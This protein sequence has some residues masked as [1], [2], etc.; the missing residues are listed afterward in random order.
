MTNESAKP[1]RLSRNLISEAG[2]GIFVVALANLGFLIYLDATRENSNPYMGIL[3][4]I[5]APAILI[6]G[7]A[8][9]AGGIFIERRKRRRLAPDEIPHYLRIDL[10][11]RRTRIILISTALGGILFVKIGRAHV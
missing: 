3:T 5:V 7:M 10:N 11:E 6:F 9:F 2:I 1:L 4:W 8:L